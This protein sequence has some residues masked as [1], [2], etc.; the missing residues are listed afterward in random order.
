LPRPRELLI[1]GEHFDPNPP[2]T[3]LLRHRG[4]RPGPQEA[5]EDDVARVAADVDDLAEQPLRLRSGEDRL[6]PEEARDLALGL[7]VV[8]HLIVEPDRGGDEA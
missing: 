6:T 5:V 1:R 3:H 4:G 2:A 7:A 8:A